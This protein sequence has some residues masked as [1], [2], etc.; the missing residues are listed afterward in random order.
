MKNKE[1]LQISDNAEPELTKVLTKAEAESG[2]SEV[3]QKYGISQDEPVVIEFR[4]SNGALLS[5]Q[6]R[7]V[8]PLNASRCCWVEAEQKGTSG[9]MEVGLTGNDTGLESTTKNDIGLELA[10]ALN[11][12]D[13][14]SSLIKVLQINS[15]SEEE[16]V[17][18]EFRSSSRVLAA[19]HVKCPC[20]RGATFCCYV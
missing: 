11:K 7:Y 5:S 14:M 17:M 3:L 13:V 4:C 12:V 2:L 10:E 8:D 16:V 9:N 18:V 19:S 6:T 1:I 20:Y 15:M